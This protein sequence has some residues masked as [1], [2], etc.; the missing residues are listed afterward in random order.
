[1]INKYI[2]IIIYIYLK[3]TNQVKSNEIKHVIMKRTSISM[4]IW[5][6]SLLPSSTPAVIHSNSMA[7]SDSS[8]LLK[9][10]KTMQ[11]PAAESTIGQ[12][13]SSRSRHRRWWM[14]HD[15]PSKYLKTLPG[16]LPH[17]LVQVHYVAAD[18]TTK[19]LYPWNKCYNVGHGGT[20]WEMVGWWAWWG[21]KW[22]NYSTVLLSHYDVDK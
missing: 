16:V 2:Y 22:F 6:F 9:P 7:C 19:M 14:T 13:W 12:I 20:W 10:G 17:S 8:E 5:C 1:M 15:H 3:K 4:Q 18:N 21:L 11:N